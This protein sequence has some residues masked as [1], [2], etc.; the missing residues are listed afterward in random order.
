MTEAGEDM[1]RLGPWCPAGGNEKWCNQ[2]GIPVIPLLG[3]DP[4]N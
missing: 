2:D 3:I 1:G 4:E